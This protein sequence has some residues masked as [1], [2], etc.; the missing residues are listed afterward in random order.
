MRTSSPS[1]LFLLETRIPSLAKHTIHQ[2]EPQANDDLCIPNFVKLANGLKEGWYQPI[3]QSV[4]NPILVQS[5]YYDV[6][7][8]LRVVE[9]LIEQAD[10]LG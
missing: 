8:L 7:L 2:V 5:V 1:V 6:K 3:S 4:V 9:N 10:H